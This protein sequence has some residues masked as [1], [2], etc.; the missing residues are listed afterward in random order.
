MIKYALICEAGHEFEG[1]FAS[2]EAF[3]TQKKRGFVTCAH[4]NTIKVDRAIMAPSVARTDLAVAS[5]DP[6]WVT[7]SDDGGLIS[8]EERELRAKLAELRAEIIK[9]ADDV[10]SDFAEEARRMHF[11]E[12]EYRR[13]YGRAS[14]DEAHALLEEGIGILPLPAALDD[15]N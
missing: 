4:C 10:G 13:I 2:S 14:P 6:S 9:D 15:R 11:G 8:P 1:W 5:V 12:K 7:D 3:E